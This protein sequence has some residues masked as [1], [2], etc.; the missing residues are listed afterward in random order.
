MREEEPR[1][2]GDGSGGK[3]LVGVCI[4]GEGGP[5]RRGQW[6]KRGASFAS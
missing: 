4:A 2:E 1:S 6:G 3:G 5:S